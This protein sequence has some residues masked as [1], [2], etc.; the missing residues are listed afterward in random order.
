MTKEKDLLHL[1]RIDGI[2]ACT[3]NEG[4]GKL[5]KISRRNLDAEC[6]EIDFYQRLAYLYMVPCC[7]D[8]ILADG[9][10]ENVR[11]SVKYIFNRAGIEENVDDIINKAIVLVNSPASFML[12]DTIIIFKKYLSK[13][14]LKG[15]I[16]DSYYMC[17]A[18]GMA[19]EEADAL[20]K[21]YQRFM[22]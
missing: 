11:T 7:Q 3:I 19:D 20:M 14:T 15:I 10:I 16:S 1:M 17:D 2:E 9:E 21:M 5:G 18:D 22:E 8:G 12:E 13:G 6:E 4:L